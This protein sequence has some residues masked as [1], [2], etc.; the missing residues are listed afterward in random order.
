MQLGVDAANE[1]GATR[2]YESV[3]MSSFMAIDALAME[4]RVD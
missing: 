3:G 1:T 2:L 4:V